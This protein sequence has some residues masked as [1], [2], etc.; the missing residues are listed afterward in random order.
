MTVRVIHD[1]GGFVRNHDV[2]NQPCPAV[3]IGA[4]S[5]D[6]YHYRV[7]DD[8]FNR[9]RLQGISGTECANADCQSLAASRVEHGQA[10]RQA[11][12]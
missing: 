10:G 1:T 8:G 5:I 6:S 9:Q 4:N 7:V 3:T 2:T 11:G 12:R